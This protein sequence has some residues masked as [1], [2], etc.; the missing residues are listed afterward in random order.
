LGVVI[1]TSALVAL[2]RAGE[3]F[4]ATSVALGDE[5]AVIPAIVYAELQVSVRLAGERSRAARRRARIEA[6]T[7]RV[8]IVEFD[9]TIAERWADLFAAL[10][11]A[12]TMI[13]GNDIQVAATAAHLDFA[14]LVG[15][16]GER[17]FAKVPGLRLARLAV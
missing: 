12:G 9:Q 6:L 16:R 3:S 2:E 1:D 11:R 15:A 7:S 13:P 8:P 10:T 4:D 5:P 17:H 14:V